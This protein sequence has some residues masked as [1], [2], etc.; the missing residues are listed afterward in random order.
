MLRGTRNPKQLIGELNYYTYCA[1]SWGAKRVTEL[2]VTGYM[3]Y[4]H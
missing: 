1:S 4:G 2:T 3:F